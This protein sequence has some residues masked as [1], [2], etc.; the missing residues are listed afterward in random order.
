MTVW[1]GSPVECSSAF[2]RLRREGSLDEEKEARALDALDSLSVFWHEVQPTPEL[3]AQAVRLLRFH[4]LRAA[5]SLQL[6]AGLSWAGTDSE[7]QLVTL[8][9]RLGTA[10]RKEGFLVLP[11]TPRTS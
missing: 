2:S 1:W 10:A 7:G 9:E 5:D 8:D 11:E 3:R 4:P 6:A